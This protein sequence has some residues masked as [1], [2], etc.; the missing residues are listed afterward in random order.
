MS[1]DSSSCHSVDQRLRIC[2]VARVVQPQKANPLARRN[3]PQAKPITTVCLVCHDTRLGTFTHQLDR[4]LPVAV[5]QSGLAPPY[6]RWRLGS[7]R[8]MMCVYAN[9]AAL[10]YRTEHSDAVKIIAFAGCVGLL[11]EH[12]S[13]LLSG[14]RFLGHSRSRCRSTYGQLCQVELSGPRQPTE[15]AYG[16]NIRAIVGDALTANFVGQ[17]YGARLA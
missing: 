4:I 3:W 1:L 17:G 8:L 15:A 2:Q 7:G 12:L 6:T 5:P 16:G 11:Q 13:Q 9:L 14:P 10:S